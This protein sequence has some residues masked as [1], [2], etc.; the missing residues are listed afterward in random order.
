MTTT[1]TT[2][3]A[4]DQLLSSFDLPTL[5]AGHTPAHAWGYFETVDDDGD[6]TWH[7]RASRDLDLAA[8]FAEVSGYLA[9]LEQADVWFEDNEAIDASAD[10]DEEDVDGDEGPLDVRFA[11][12]SFEEFPGELTGRFLLLVLSEDAEG[13]AAQDVWTPGL[14]DEEIMGLLRLA[15]LRLTD[16]LLWEIDTPTSST[17]TPEPEQVSLTSLFP[18]WEF[19]SVDEDA[20]IDGVWA[21]IETTDDDGGTGWVQRETPGLDRAE[22]LALMSVKVTGLESRMLAEWELVDAAEWDEDSEDEDTADI[23]DD[24]LGTE[25]GAGEPGEESELD[26]A[27]EDDLDADV[28]LDPNDPEAAARLA[29]AIAALAEGDDEDEELVLL[30]DRFDQL[31]VAALPEGTRARRALLVVLASEGDERPR[32]ALYGADPAEELDF[33]YVNDFEELGLLRGQERRLRDELAW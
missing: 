11:A 30:D 1:T 21:V 22:L 29:R 8:V 23:D 5:A 2:S 12:L 10:S 7:E 28:D 4:L 27:D 15:Q 32:Y 33:P 14:G 13:E 25:P 17:L 18:G 9:G 6:A 24:D 16:A 26:G 20:T 31:T 19:E 3:V